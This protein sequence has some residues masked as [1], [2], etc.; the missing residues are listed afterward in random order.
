MEQNFFSHLVEDRS[1]FNGGNFTYSEFMTIIMRN[2][3]GMA[4]TTTTAT[5]SMPRR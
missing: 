3:S 4:A 2:S 1:N 5:T